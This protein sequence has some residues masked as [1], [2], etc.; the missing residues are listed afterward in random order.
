MFIR[1]FNRP[2]LGLKAI[3]FFL[4]LFLT[5]QEQIPHR[6]SCSS[7]LFISD[8]TA[9]CDIWHYRRSP[10]NSPGRGIFGQAQTKRSG[11]GGAAA[12]HLNPPLIPLLMHGYK[13]ATGQKPVL[14]RARRHPGVATPGR[15]HAINTGG[16][17]VAWSRVKRRLLLEEAVPHPE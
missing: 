15:A 6:Y 7:A 2:K 12:V 17:N 14:L 10:A 11:G 1:K 5:R 9:L 8:V 3:F 16:G 13:Y 4:S